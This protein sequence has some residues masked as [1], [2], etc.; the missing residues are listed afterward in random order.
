MYE[1]NE[2]VGPGH[3]RNVT[4]RETLEE[5]RETRDILAGAAWPRGACYRIWDPE[6]KRYVDDDEV[7]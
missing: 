5:A 4:T 6:L 1:I 2:I 7:D 3:I